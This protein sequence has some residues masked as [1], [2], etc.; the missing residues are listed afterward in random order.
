MRAREKPLAPRVHSLESTRSDPLA[1]GPEVR[2]RERVACHS[3][4]SLI[5]SRNMSDE[6]GNTWAG[7]RR[8]VLLTYTKGACGSFQWN[9]CSEVLNRLISEVRRPKTDAARKSFSYRGAVLWNGLLMK[10]KRSH[11]LLLLKKSLRV[12]NFDRA[13]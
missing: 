11:Q 2:M 5:R 3:M 8:H 7:T 9:I 13:F 12:L 10:I 4:T 1:R 6:E